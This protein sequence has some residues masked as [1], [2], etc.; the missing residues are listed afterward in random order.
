M[1]GASCMRLPGSFASKRTEMPSSGCTFTTSRFDAIGVALTRLKMC[2][3]G[4]R[5][6]IAIS[7]VRFGI[8]LPVRM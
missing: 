8:R 2:S 1:T 7:V 4:L 6:W 5:N 3:G